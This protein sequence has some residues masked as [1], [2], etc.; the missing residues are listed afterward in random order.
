MNTDIATDPRVDR[1]YALLPAVHRMRDAERGY[2]LKALLRVIAE[3]VNVVE[4]D[5]AQLYENQFIETADDWA[6]PYLGDLVGYRPVAEAG[7]PAD[8]PGCEA[9]RVLVP[10]R[11]VANTIRYRRRKGTLALLEQLANDIGGWPARAVEFFKLLAWAQNLQHLHPDRHRTVDLRQV[12]ALE[13]LDGPFDRIT[14][15]VDLRRIGSQRTRGRCNIPSVGVFVWRLRSCSVTL[16]PACCIEESGPHCFSFSVLG[17]DA[18]LYVRPQPETDP[19]RIAGELDLPVPI[20]RTAFDARIADFVG[21]DASLSIRVDG[22]GGLT[23]SDPVPVAQLL[24]ADLSDWRYV[25][26]LNRIAVDPVLGRLAFPPSQLPKK[27]V[28]VS[29]HYGFP[30]DIG[31]GEYGRPILQPAVP[32]ALPPAKAFELYRVGEGETHRR[33]GEALA[34]WQH[35]RPQHAVIEFAAS[36]VYVEPIEIVLADHQTLQLRAANRTRPVLRLIDWQTDLPDALTVTLGEGSRITLDGLLVT[37]RP[38]QILGAT[39]GEGAST[40]GGEVVIRHCT[41]VPGWG[42]DCDCEPKRPAEPSL[43]LSNV[44]ARVRIEHS[45]VG[46]IQVHEDE[47]RQDPIA[48]CI[49]DSIVDATSAQRQAIGAPGASW[50]HTTLT[51]Q[52]CTVFG[53]VDVH[54]MALGENCIFSGCVNVARRQIGCMRFC[55]VPTECRTPRRYHCQPDGVVAA[56]KARVTDD[57]ARQASEI[58][59]ETL[60]VEP[61]FSARRYGRPA[62][63]QLGPGCA[64]EI[65][66]GADDES[67]LGV[68]H[69]LYQP[70][71]E[72]NLRTRLTE[73]TPAG[74]NVGIVFAS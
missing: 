1:L 73:Y 71:R 57:A 15:S 74:M 54:A 23:G 37:G 24:A 69:D 59:N 17:Q 19:T 41:L 21:V 51:I 11:E 67:E 9:P 4:D 22:W 70:Q 55:W 25:P 65:T 30:A 72:A 29:Y 40:C 43:A 5:I 46:A 39:P 31:G 60:R 58:A 44:R 66:R 13:L 27:G 34:Q 68:Y 18:P 62:Y 53:I 49:A 32:P 8:G 14:H 36:G 63:A 26:P 45:I 3:Q 10:R 16:T 2:P 48:L 38:V 42:I 47:V 50:A 12:E 61:Q 56:V 35:D 64:V 7:A 6:V 52:R 28:R 33:V 20:R